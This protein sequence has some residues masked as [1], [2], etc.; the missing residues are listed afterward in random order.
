MASKLVAASGRDPE[1][2]RASLEGRG[3]ALRSWS[4]GPGDTYGWH[5]H[6]YHKT[7]V[8]LAGSIVFHT[9]DGDVTLSA[10]DVLELEPGTRHGATV[11]PKG[12][13]C[14]EAAT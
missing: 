9:D 7:L 12:V 14:A 3:L 2:V 13:R 1:K 6:S 11:G 5:D 10:G 4:N 8:C